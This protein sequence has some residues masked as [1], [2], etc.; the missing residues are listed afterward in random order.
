[1]SN[2]AG[3]AIA[4]FFMM[5][6]M[7]LA[8]QLACE[9]GWYSR[10][11]RLAFKGLTTMLAAALALYAYRETGQTYALVM[12]GGILLCAAADVMLELKFLA[13]TALFALGHLAYIVSFWVRSKP[14]TASILLFGALAA[15]GTI[16]ALWARRKVKFSVLP[17]YLY[18]LVISLMVASALAQPPLAFLGA[19]LF[20]LSDAI[21][22]RRLVLPDRNPWDRACIL[23]YYLAQFVLAYSLLS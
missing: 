4:V 2:Q 8:Y 23:L 15:L 14:G 3:F 16:V 7:G 9:T 10:A 11:A 12:A 17:F 19:V 6:S 18:I 20:F 1:M 21:I 5:L 22:G 13:G